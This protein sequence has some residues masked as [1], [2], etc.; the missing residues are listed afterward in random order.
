MRPGAKSLL[1]RLLAPAA[2]EVEECEACLQD[3]PAAEAL[4]ARDIVY[5]PDFVINS[6][7]VISGSVAL[8][9]ETHDDMVRRVDG[10]YDTTREV[11]DHA[12]RERITTLRAAEM[13]AEMTLANARR[14]DR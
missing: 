6:G 2:A 14:D 1:L 5:A 8:L 3:R 9:N 7:G 13:R 12:A 10:I 4:S 11:L